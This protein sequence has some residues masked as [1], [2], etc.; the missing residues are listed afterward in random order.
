MKQILDPERVSLKED[1]LNFVFDSY[2]NLLLFELLINH[3][4]DVKFLTIPC[5]VAVL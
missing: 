1:V 3:P 5:L 2:S 4:E